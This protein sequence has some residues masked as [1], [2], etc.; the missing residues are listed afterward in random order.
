MIVVVGALFTTIQML[1]A[2]GRYIVGQHASERLEERGILEWQVVTGLEEGT[3][4]RE[5]PNAEPNPAVEVDQQLADGTPIKA[6][7]SHLRAS[8][9]AKL[10]TVHY[11]D[12]Q[13]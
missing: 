3:L 7:S 9:V 6:V 8:D 5:R 2:S 10:V 11:H 13:D 12:E 4:L 1:V